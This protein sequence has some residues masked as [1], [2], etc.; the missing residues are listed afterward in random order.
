L[1]DN[2]GKLMSLHRSMTSAGIGCEFEPKAQQSVS[3]L[4]IGQQVTIKG[5]CSGA[6]MDV[7]MVDC[8]IVSEK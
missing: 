8:T 3:K 7:V 1:R 4:K 5:I 2:T 6:L